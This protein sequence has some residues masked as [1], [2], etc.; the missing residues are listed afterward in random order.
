MPIPSL[1]LK[2]KDLSHAEKQR[3]WSRSCGLQEVLHNTLEV[4]DQTKNGLLDDPCK[5]FPTTN[6]QS[7]VFGLPGNIL[8]PVLHCAWIMPIPSL[9]LKKKDMS[10]AEKQRVWSRSCGLQEVLHNILIPVLHCACI[11][12]IPSLQLK[13]KDLSHAEKQRVWSRSCGLQ[14]VLHNIL[15][16]VLHCA[17]IMP[18]R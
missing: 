3:V 4:Q 18:I 12:P 16:P 8:I 15:I 14:E 5:G 2:K 9:Q 7:L 6:G 17:C 11:M 10:H 13:K 1:Q